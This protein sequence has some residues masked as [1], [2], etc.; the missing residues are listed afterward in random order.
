M[1]FI[2]Y[3]TSCFLGSF[4]SGVPSSLLNIQKMGWVMI[5]IGPLRNS[6]LKAL[7][8]TNEI[9]NADLQFCF[10]LFSEPLTSKTYK[11]IRNDYKQQSNQMSFSNW[12]TYIK[13]HFIERC[14]G[15]RKEKTCSWIHHPKLCKHRQNLHEALNNFHLEK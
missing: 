4:Q 14:L 3:F 11:D 13:K 1:Q 15:N 5:K 9:Q 8:F 7:Y 12:H 6:S 10:R 2:L